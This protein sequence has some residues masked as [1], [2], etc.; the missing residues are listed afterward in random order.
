MVEG[1]SNAHT[2]IFKSN[3]HTLYTLYSRSDSGAIGFF[4]SFE[5]S[6]GRQP[7]YVAHCGLFPY[8]KLAKSTLKD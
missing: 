7:S 1:E 3:A 4:I 6:I 5:R 2:F 8:Q